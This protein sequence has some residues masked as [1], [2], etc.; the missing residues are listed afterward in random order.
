MHFPKRVGSKRERDPDNLQLLTDHRAKFQSTGVNLII[1]A[2]MQFAICF[3]TRR[4]VCLVRRGH[5]SLQRKKV[6]Y[7]KNQHLTKADI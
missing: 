6:C 3:C 7:E 2:G 5:F 4:A 1:I